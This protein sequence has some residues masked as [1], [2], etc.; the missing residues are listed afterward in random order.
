MVLR[1]GCDLPLESS[2]KN[3]EVQQRRLSWL[4]EQN[5][6]DKAFMVELENARGMSLA[7][8]L[9]D[10]NSMR[11]EFRVLEAYIHLV[12]H[13]FCVTLNFTRNHCFLRVEKTSEMALDPS[14]Q[15]SL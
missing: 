8:K 9:Q 7:P 14:C 6:R 1:K 4:S 10:E 11:A 13:T 2:Q 15:A 3:H 12:L 5:C